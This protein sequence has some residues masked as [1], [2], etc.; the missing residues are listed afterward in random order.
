AKAS[1]ALAIA[2]IFPPGTTI[3]RFAL[4]MAWSFGLVGIGLLLGMAISCGR[5]TSWHDSPEVQCDIPNVL[6]AAAFCATL[7]SDAL[8][9][10]TPLRMLWWMK[11]PGEQRRLILAG[12]AASVWMSVAGGI[13]FIFMFGPDSWGLPRKVI[14][15]LLGHAM[16]SISLM[17]CNSMVIVTY[18]YRLV[19]SDK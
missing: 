4:G 1:L 6:I 14:P 10:F 2:R 8:L 13:C 9:I 7:I 11:L 15:P 16:A 12:F 3:R 19:Q 17:V 5:D 18:V